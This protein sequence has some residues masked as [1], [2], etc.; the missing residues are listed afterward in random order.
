MTFVR[1]SAGKKRCGHSDAAAGPLF[2]NSKCRAPG[3]WIYADQPEAIYG[4]LC[5]RHM[6]RRIDAGEAD[7]RPSLCG[8]IRFCRDW[9]VCQVECGGDPRRGCRAQAQ[10]DFAHVFA[11]R[12]SAPRQNRSWRFRS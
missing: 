3:E 5:T 9:R 10:P 1:V 11:A 8:G 2:A 12:R 6:L 7:G 4:R